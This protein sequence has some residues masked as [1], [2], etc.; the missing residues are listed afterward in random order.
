MSLLSLVSAANSALLLSNLAAKAAEEVSTA[1]KTAAMHAKAAL[2]AA[3]L[4]LDIERKVNQTEKYDNIMLEGE[5]GEGVL[6]LKHLN[7]MK[8]AQPHIR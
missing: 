2:A 3:E 8:Y 7:D 1:A 5:V 4:A 6:T